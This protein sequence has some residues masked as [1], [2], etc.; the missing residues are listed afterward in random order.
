MMSTNCLGYLEESMVNWKKR[1]YSGAWK[2][3]E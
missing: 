2:D 1:Q 3:G